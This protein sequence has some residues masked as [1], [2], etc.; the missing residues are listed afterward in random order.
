MMRDDTGDWP[1]ST[2]AIAA[3]LSVSGQKRYDNLQTEADA[4]T[5]DVAETQEAFEAAWVEVESAFQSFLS[6]AK[7]EAE[8]VRDVLAA[9]AH[10]QRQSWEKSLKNLG[11]QAS[12]AVEKARGEFDAALKRLSG[13]AERFQNRIGEAKDAGDES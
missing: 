6:A 10:A 5:R 12:Q 7:D 13:E 9:R 1:S 4:V 3:R 2:T 8:I 11:D